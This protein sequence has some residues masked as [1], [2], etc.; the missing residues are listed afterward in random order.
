MFGGDGLAREVVVQLRAEDLRT[1]WTA[2]SDQHR[3]LNS[4]FGEMV[5]VRRDVGPAAEPAVAV[6]V[7]DAVWSDRRPA[8]V[9]LHRR[10]EGAAAEEV[11]VGADGVDERLHQT[12]GHDVVRVRLEV[13]RVLVVVGCERLTAQEVQVGRVAQRQTR[14][15][16]E[17]LEVAADAVAD[18]SVDALGSVEPGREGAAVADREQVG[19]AVL[20]DRS[21]DARSGR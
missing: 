3:D 19:L 17:R 11:V 13:T 7:V 12:A 10:G 18:E 16:V 14:A 6:R 4:P 5:L 15:A 1:F 20:E 9:H 2:S 8:D 21:A